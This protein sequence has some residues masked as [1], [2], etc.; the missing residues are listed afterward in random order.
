MDVAAKLWECKVATLML[1]PAYSSP[2]EDP[3]IRAATV[4]R[5]QKYQRINAD[6][7]TIVGDRDQ[8]RLRVL[9]VAIEQKIAGAAVESFNQGV[10]RP[11]VLQSVVQ[12]AQ[13]GDIKSLTNI[14]Y[15]KAETFDI[16]ADTQ[17][18]SRYALEIASKDPV[19]GEMVRPYLRTAEIISVPV[20]GEA[21]P[22]FDDSNLSDEVRKEGKAIAERLIS[23]I[24]RGGQ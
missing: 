13:A 18:A 19:V 15:H 3:G 22:K 21:K 14:A 9:D 8:G 17:R 6:C 24:K 10:R 16:S 5:T 2:S 23:R 1:D 12:D 7:Q 11:D 4:E 20:G